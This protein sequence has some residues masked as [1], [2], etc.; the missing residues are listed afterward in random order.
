MGPFPG[1]VSQR[2]PILGLTLAASAEVEGAFCPELIA[3]FYVWSRVADQESQIE[4]RLPSKDIRCLSVFMLCRVVDVIVDWLPELRTY[5]SFFPDLAYFLPDFRAG[6]EPVDEE[7]E[8]PVGMLLQSLLPSDRQQR[9]ILQSHFEQVAE[10]LSPKLE[11]ERIESKPF[12]PLKYRWSWSSI[13]PR[14]AS[15][16]G[17]QGPK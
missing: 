5:I 12:D 9:L 1:W 16:R 13:S 14:D 11:E 4:S 6:T 15:Q 10:E 7:R 2:L 8:T 17:A 3:G